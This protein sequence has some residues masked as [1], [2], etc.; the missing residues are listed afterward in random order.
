MGTDGLVAICTWRSW[1]SPRVSSPRE[2]YIGVQVG[3]FTQ[4]ISRA[5][6][7]SNQRQYDSATIFC[8]KSTS[9]VLETMAVFFCLFLE[10]DPF[11]VSANTKYNHVIMN[12]EAC[13]ACGSGKLTEL[14][15]LEG[16]IQGSSFAVL[17]CD[18][19][20]SHMTMPHTSE[21]RVYELIYTHR[22]TVPGYSRYAQY[23]EDV[24]HVSSP[25]AFLSHKEEMY[26]GVA[27]EIKN[28]SKK[29]ISIL[30]VGCGLGYM[31]YALNKAGYKVTGLDISEEA[32]GVA[33][34]TYGDFFV[35]DD[36]FKH[37]TQ[38]SYDVICMLELIE[39]VRDPHAYIAHAR[40]LLKPGGK[41]IVTTPNRSWYADEDVWNTD[42][43]PVH[44]SWFSEEGASKLLAAHGFTP[45]LFT[46]TRYNFFHG[47][48]LRPLP[49]TSIRSSIFSSTGELLTPHY[50]KSRV[51]ILTE[52]LHVYGLLKGGI[53][54]FRKIGEVLSLMRHPQRLSLKRSNI[55]CISA[56][57]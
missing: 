28:I 17:A 15:T 57:L 40:T 26:H 50:E 21:D 8:K 20:K 9:D 3:T 32:I 49:A 34:T 23:A 14:T 24:L 46:Y 33:R 18:D 55:L 22:H 7:S 43:P 16:Y 12:K 45:K 35:C 11:G 27:Q 29:D 39:H 10:A 30:D 48:I 44:I 52:K 38:E 37:Q 4:R 51:R 6:G 56:T 1:R 31:T 53:S 5:R 41:L 54:F 25:L 42:L 47:T 2:E 13:C 19:C 36:F